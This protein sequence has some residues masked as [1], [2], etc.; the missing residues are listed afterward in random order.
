VVA[1]WNPAAASSYYTRRRETDYYTKS[2][3]PEGVWYAPGC[4]FGLVDGQTVDPQTFERLYAAV[5]EHGRSL[6][7]KIRRHAERTPAFDVTFS[8]PRSVSLAW[9][10]APADVKA[11]IEAAQQRAVRAA[12]D[13]IEREA[14]WARRGRNGDRIEKVRLS[15]AMFQHGESRAAKHSDGAIFGDANLHTHGVCLNIATRADG[16]IGGLHS[17][18]LRDFKMAAGAFYH[19]ALAFELTNSIGFEIDCTENATNG[20][21]ELVGV[22]KAVI[23]YFSAR[24]NEIENE[25]SKYELT[26]DQAVALAAA[27]TRGSRSSKRPHTRSR[28]EIWVDAARSLGIDVERFT[29]SLIRQER[30][31]DPG[32]AE[33]LLVERLAALPAAL[34]EHESVI[35]RRELVRSVAAAFV[36]T[37]LPIE[38]AEYEVNRLLREGAFIEIGRDPLGLPRYS[39]PEMIKIEREVVTLARELASRSWQH[40]E[41]HAVDASCRAA[42]LTAEQVDAVRAAVDAS[43]IGVI[44]GAPGVGKS[45]TLAS[46]SSIY[47]AAGCRVLGTA[48]AWRVATAL[49]ED[50]GIDSR[51]TASWI[52]SIK[53]GQK[54]FDERSVL[55]CDEAG[56]LSSRQMHVLLDAVARS[57]AKLLLV[58]DRRQLQAIG[59]PGLDLVIRAVE[60]ARIDTIVRQREIWAREAVANF[61]AGRAADAL[62]A[63]AERDL[64]IEAQGAKAAVTAVIEQADRARARHP[65]GTVLILAKSNATVAEISREIRNRR[66]TARL[67]TGKETA[68]TAA[69]PSAQRRASTCAWRPDQ[70]LGPE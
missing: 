57:H 30:S 10:F 70:V 2:R 16:T 47:R 67:I 42:G 37:R 36:G 62:S 55:I 13:M 33:R 40:A 68:F 59:G 50:L 8:A 24:R 20:I 63:F 46:I 26:S 61:G 39:T 45:T 19:A 3:E 65:S 58:G 1:T 4:D 44:E 48:T 60:P 43:A 56:L 22:D 51:A 5:D 38:R 17:K 21:F 52:A 28:E 53:L 12:L 7:E 18:I 49:K 29:T 35:D 31:F 23:R 32:H 64:L 14:V 34:T 11:Q 15:A 41:K 9:A 27:I 6:L 54:V 66:K 69:T 25:L